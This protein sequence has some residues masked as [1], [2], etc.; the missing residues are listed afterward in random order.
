MKKV[1][2]LI[3]SF[4]LALSVGSVNV[5]AVEDTGEVPLYE[6]SEEVFE[7]EDIARQEPEDEGVDAKNLTEEDPIYNE[8]ELDETGSQ[9]PAMPEEEKDP[10]ETQEPDENA[11]ENA[12]ESDIEFFADDQDQPDDTDDTDDTE[13]TKIP[14]SLEYDDRYSLNDLPAISKAGEE[15]KISEIFSE[16]ESY[17]V[18]S[19]KK[20]GTMDEVITQVSEDSL[21][22]VA[23]GVGTAIIY[24]VPVSQEAAKG[25][26]QTEDTGEPETGF[27][28]NVKV[29]PAVLTLMY[30][31][32]QSNMEGRVSTST[33]Y[34]L[35]ASVA[36]EEGT[37]YSTYAP[38]N[39][40]SDQIAGLTF[41]SYCSASNASDFVAGSLQGSTSVSGKSLTYA[42]DSLTTQGSGKAGPDSGLAYEWNKLTGD[43]VWVVNT[44]WSGTGIASWI[45]GATQYKRSAAVWNYVDQVYKAELSAG[46]YTGG[47]KLAFWL[48]GE[49]D[50][51][52]QTAVEDYIS[53]FTSMYTSMKSELGLNAF[54]IIMVRGSGT[55]DSTTG[56]YTT[57]K[58][59]K[60]SSPRIAQYMF[61][62]SSGLS[63]VY[64][65]SN[66]NEQWVS[67]SGVKSYFKSAYPGGKLDYPMQGSTK[68]SLPTTVNAVHSD[69]HYSQIGHNENGIT[70]ADGMYQVLYGSTTPKSVSW[71]D[72]DG[73]SVSSMTLLVT[74][75]TAVAVPVADPVYS[76]KKVTF[77]VSGSGISYNSQNGLVTAKS[78]GSYK[79]LASYEGKS[80][81]LT[82]K[83]S[84][85]KDLSSAAGSNYT[86]LYKYNGNWWYLKNGVIQRDYESVVKN[87]NGWWYVKDGMVDFDYTGFAENSNGWWYIE[88]GQ[89]TFKKNGVIKDDDGKIDGTASWYYVVGS[90]V[91]LNFTG[92]ADYS[93]ENGW[94]YIN[95]GKV[96]FNVTTVAKNTNGWFYVEDS[97]VN[98]NYNGFAKNSNGW[99]YI[100]NGRVTFNKNSVIQDTGKKID[101]AASWW[102][103]TGSKVQTGFTGLAD[104]SNANGWWYI[105]NG[106]VSFSANTVA[107]N[108]NGWW[109]VEGSQVKFNYNGFAKNS[110]GWWYIENGKVTFKKNSV[111]K[112]AAKTIDGTQSWYYV[113]GSQV[114]QNFTG[115]AD[116]SNENGWWYI[117]NGKVDF[118][119]NTVAKNKNG[120][121]YI[122]GGQVKFGFT[123]LA[124]YSNENGWW[125]I[126]KGQV[127]FSFNGIASNKNGSWYIKN[128]KVDFSYNG[129][130]TY[131]K[132]RY[133]I[134]NGKVQ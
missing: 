21:D 8:D 99:W 46:H 114:K 103:V 47:S 90:Q 40:N 113:V 111:I 121:W 23:T 96:T 93:N 74:G 5:L 109:Y 116:Y 71:K 77:S 128:G 65:V 53:D 9:D 105:N 94:W 48:Q 87:E 39:S 52:A 61:G 107:K 120:W 13:W 89:V 98:F 108:K 22:I 63:G 79:L 42:I 91:K 110:N 33:G 49:S 15:Y 26:D 127:D 85:P 95:D 88:N 75:D 86:G 51:T 12:D 35:N 83:V 36:C 34:E 81:E 56:A 38:T 54:G 122:L 64:V 18:V 68:T 24:M 115:L 43:K 118:S 69:V 72:E 57:N 82:V 25:T 124:D 37:V 119:A 100:E 125:Y 84:V 17:Q 134:V 76:A 66:A 14:L 19:G 29:E 28:I 117:K 16:A 55:S 20:T 1:S 6:K 104:Y 59:L 70:A 129:F 106:K 78:T 126:E 32:G 41:S 112:D 123:G 132:T 10:A 31:T 97:K 44:A 80:S 50:T 73:N 92:L 7:E 4:I 2:C 130:F 67:D 45:P 58:D 133:R 30:L 27:Q 62:G 3:L 131:K 102:Y 101:G 11:G 60:M